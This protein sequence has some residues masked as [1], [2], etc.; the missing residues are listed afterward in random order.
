MAN[1][2]PLSEINLSKTVPPQKKDTGKISNVAFEIS[3]PTNVPDNFQ[4]VFQNYYTA[5]IVIVQDIGTGPKV[6]MENKKLMECASN[7][8]EACLWHSIPGSQLFSKGLVRGKPIKI[9][10]FQSCDIWNKIDLRNIKVVF[11]RSAAEGSPRLGSVAV[12]DSG[13]SSVQKNANSITTSSSLSSLI[14]SDF[15]I[16]TEA[17]RVQSSMKLPPE[18]YYNQADDHKR[19][20]RRK[21]KRSKDLRKSMGNY[22]GSLPMN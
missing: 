12:H 20:S 22:D 21:D 3:V 9:Y 14:L 10:L 8:A 4:L 17:A 11:Q 13:S 6:L 16:L 7:E 5:N 15:K 19:S 18:S 1:L 2:N